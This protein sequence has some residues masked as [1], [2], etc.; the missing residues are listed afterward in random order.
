[1]FLAVSRLLHRRFGLMFRT[2]PNSR[3]TSVCANGGSP[4]GPCLRREGRY[5][6]LPRHRSSRQESPFRRLLS[7]AAIGCSFGIS[8]SAPRSRSFCC[9]RACRPACA[10][11][12]AD[13]VVEG[14]S[15]PDLLHLLSWSITTVLQFPLAVYE[16]YIREHKY[17]LATQTFGPWMRDQLV[18]L[19]SGRGSRWYCGDGALR[20]SPSA[21]KDLVGMGRSGEH[22]VSGRS[23][24]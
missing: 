14:C 22:C 16:G 6:R 18:G 10:T 23:F 19:A 17:G 13:V 7:K 9:S 12:Q 1:M 24:S 15:R 11:G 5:R 8:C 2:A 4:L 20:A 3:R 21:G